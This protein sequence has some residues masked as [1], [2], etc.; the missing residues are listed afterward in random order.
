MRHLTLLGLIL[1]CM[2]AKASAQQTYAEGITGPWN[3]GFKC[4]ISQLD[5]EFAKAYKYTRHRDSF[6]PECFFPPSLNWTDDEQ[7]LYEV[8]SKRNSQPNFDTFTRRMLTTG[9]CWLSLHSDPKYQKSGLVNT[10]DW[11]LV[12]VPE[13]LSPKW[14]GVFWSLAQKQYRR[15]WIQF[16]HETFIQDKKEEEAS[17]N[18]LQFVDDATATKVKAEDVVDRR[19]TTRQK[20]IESRVKTHAKVLDF[21]K[22]KPYTP[23]QSPNETPL[24]QR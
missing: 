9:S 6:A 3:D 19:T 7:K 13:G 12:T 17:K 20:Y 22:G 10:Y 4:Q 11:S 16:Q 8:L 24:T 14:E 18:V 23:G 2:A 1:T 21:F 5:D 15:F